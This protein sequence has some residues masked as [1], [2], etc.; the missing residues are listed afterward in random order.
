MCHH[1]SYVITTNTFVIDKICL[2]T[3]RRYSMVGTLGA[4]FTYDSPI[5]TVITVN[6]PEATDAVVTITGLNYG[7]YDVSPTGMVITTWT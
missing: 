7:E 2:R 5:M 1:S 6:A 3:I 4:F